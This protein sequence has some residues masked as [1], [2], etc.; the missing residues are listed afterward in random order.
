MNIRDLKVKKIDYKTAMDLVVDKHYLKRKCSCSLAFG[1]FISEDN[2]TDLFNKETIVGVIVFGK[3]SS[4]TLCNGICGDEESKNVIEFNRLWVDDCM[5]KNTESF[6]VA[7]AIKQCPFEIIVSFADSEQGHKGFIY[8]ATN[9]IYT[10]ISPKMKYY[11]PKIESTNTGGTI[12]RRRERMTKQ[13][14]IEK[15]GEN[16]I[17]E[18]FSSM[19]HR[20]IYF[21]ASKKRKKELISKLNY[22]VS[23]YPK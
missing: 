14:I 2:N 23:N 9:W 11:R 12:Y 10:G 17:E 21:N 7:K 6:F 8:Q 19:K 5:P 4:Y 18:Y 15:Y 3:P 22:K 1:L 20:Y 16:M 13:A